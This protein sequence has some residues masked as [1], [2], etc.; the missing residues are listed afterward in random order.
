MKKEAGFKGQRTVILPEFIINEIQKDAMGKQL[1]L[2]DIGYY[3]HAQFHYFKRKEGSSEYILI[4]C[5]E[6]RGWFSLEGKKVNVYANQYFIIPKG[7]TH[8]YGADNKDP[9]SIY[10]M[11]FSGVQ[12]SHFDD[13]SGKMR[14]ISPSNI[15]RIDYRIELFEEILQNLEMG[16]SKEN[17]QYAN[18]CLYHFLASFKYIRQFRQ[19]RTKREK[20]LVDDAIYHMRE[21][22]S[23]KLT[24]DSIAAHAGLSASQFSLLFRRKTGRSVMDYLIHLRVQRACQYLDNTELKVKEIAAMVGYDD[25]YYFSRIFKKVMGNSPAQYRIMPK[26]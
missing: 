4:Y 9:W 10:W 18:I 17:L 20:D 15:S 24:L 12:A 25:P 8:S 13:I 26:G 3:P 6:G 23:K 1:Y 5:T 7:V 19:I 16:Y 2:T 22:I 14:L 11:H 21:F